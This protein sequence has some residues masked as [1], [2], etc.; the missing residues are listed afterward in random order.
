[1]TNLLAFNKLIISLS[2]VNILAFNKYYMVP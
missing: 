2:M 1:M